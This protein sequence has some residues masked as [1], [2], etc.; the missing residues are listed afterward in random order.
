VPLGRWSYAEIARRLVALGL[1]VSIAVSTIARWLAAEKLKP[2]RY[3]TWQHIL[4]PRA[5]LERARPILNLYRKAQALWEE[6]VWVVCV[7]E[8]TS[9][10]ARQRKPPPEPAIPGQPVHIPSRYRRRGAWQRFAGLSV[11]DGMVFG[12]CWERKR[13]V[14]FQA[15]LLE[16]LFPE[17]LKR[18]GRTLVLILDNSTTHAPKQWEGWL[19][20]QL[21]RNEL[22]QSCTK[23]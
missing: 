2:W 11:V 17:A 14:D 20:E 21:D 5:F 7:D 4:D 8:K 13:F 22:V 6:G 19:Q 18:G 16:T 12:Q 1:V 3:H 15:F 10:Q 9:L 23:D